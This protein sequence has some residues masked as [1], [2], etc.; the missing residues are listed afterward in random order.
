MRN[1]WYFE[2]LLPYVPSLLVARRESQPVSFRPICLERWSPPVRTVD[3]FFVLV[4][5]Y[6]SFQHGHFGYFHSSFLHVGASSILPVQIDSISPHSF[7]FS[8]IIPSSYTVYPSLP[9]LCPC[10]IRLI[11]PCCSLS[12]LTV[13]RYWRPMM[14]ISFVDAVLVLMCGNVE[15][16]LVRVST[17]HYSMEPARFI[18]PAVSASFII[19]LE[20]AYTAML[21]I[22]KIQ[23][24]LHLLRLLSNSTVRRLFNIANTYNPA[25]IAV[26]RTRKFTAPHLM[27][28][29]DHCL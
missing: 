11:S 4:G 14:K 21:S 27:S 23:D 10:H 18:L 15:C 26:L 16:I 8:C 25:L 13:P 17:S 28:S 22:F 2:T 9:S 3:A 1:P 6:G 12:L 19:A 7:V 24:T 20:R 5:I 29:T